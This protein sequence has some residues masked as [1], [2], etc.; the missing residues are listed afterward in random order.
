DE[1][2]LAWKVVALDKK[3]G[4]SASADMSIEWIFSYF[5]I[6]KSHLLFEFKEALEWGPNVTQKWTVVSQTC[7]LD[8]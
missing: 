5:R 8:N 6:D 2:N 4:D 7:I 3:E 1:T